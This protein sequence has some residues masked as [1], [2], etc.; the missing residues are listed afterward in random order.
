M[1]YV[2]SELQKKHIHKLS[3]K[4]NKGLKKN[5]VTKKSKK[6]K[7]HFSEDIL[8]C[9][10]EMYEPKVECDDEDKSSV[11]YSCTMCERKFRKLLT[12]NLH[13]KKHEEQMSKVYTC[14]QCKRFVLFLTYCECYFI[15]Q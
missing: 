11:P 1:G 5:G 2:T 12:L 8:Q 10:D 15:F 13:L 4:A 9:T 14:H 6:R 3:K 7:H